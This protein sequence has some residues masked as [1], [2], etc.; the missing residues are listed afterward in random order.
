M[1]LAPFELTIGRNKLSAR[2]RLCVGFF[3]GLSRR[4]LDLVTQLRGKPGFYNGTHEDIPRLGIFNSVIL[5]RVAEERALPRCDVSLG[6]STLLTTLLQR[7]HNHLPAARHGLRLS[8][9]VR[10]SL[11]YVNIMGDREGQ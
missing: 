8:L 4:V 10:L 9:T 5:A 2:S 3:I 1:E 7:R 6:Q 11:I